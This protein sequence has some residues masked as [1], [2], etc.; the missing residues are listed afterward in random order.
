MIHGLNLQSTHFS[1]HLVPSLARTSR[2]IVQKMGQVATN[3]RPLSD[4]LLL[5]G[6]G[7][8]VAVLVVGYFL[9]GDSWHVSKKLQLYVALNAGFCI[10]A[11]WR[12]RSWF[13]RPRL[14]FLLPIWLVGHL[15]VYGFL[16]YA[17]FNF[18][19]YIFLFPVEMAVMRWIEL[20]RAAIHRQKEIGHADRNA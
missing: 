7:V 11:L 4:T 12:F 5:W 3:K 8:F 2:T 16:A 15:L 18:L 13:R 6:T 1:G 9:I 20:R 19:L 10:L 17:G 14:R